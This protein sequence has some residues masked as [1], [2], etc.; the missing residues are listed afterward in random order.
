MT[1]RGV[2]VLGAAVDWISRQ[3]SGGVLAT[4]VLLAGMF[5]PYHP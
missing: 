5:T 3:A 2:A 1:G 4:C